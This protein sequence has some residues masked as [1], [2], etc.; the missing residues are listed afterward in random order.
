M[1]RYLAL[2]I[3]TIVAVTGLMATSVYAD[4]NAN[5]ETTSDSEP[6][7]EYVSDFVRADETLKK[8]TRTYEIVPGSSNTKSKDF[9][10]NGKRYATKSYTIEGITYVPVSIIKDLSTSK[11]TANYNIS[12]KVTDVSD[13]I[14]SKASYSSQDPDSEVYHHITFTT[15]DKTAKK[16][17]QR[18]D[19]VYNYN[20][21]LTLK[22]TATVNGKSKTTTLPLSKYAVYVDDNN[23]DYLPVQF[24][25]DILGY[26][27]TKDSKG[28]YN[29]TGFLNNNFNR[30]F[31]V[32]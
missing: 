1:K 8:E 4:A 25:N 32:K 19:E 31:N 28:T 29:V 10:V 12:Y 7:I 15:V 22:C 17:R 24:F 13:S 20:G 21:R 26:K 11:A 3:A 6:K 18:V 23:V 5:I 14:K 30:F 2:T 9:M 16:G 27:V